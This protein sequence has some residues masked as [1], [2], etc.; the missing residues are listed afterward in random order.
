MWKIRN[1]IDFI[2]DFIIA[3]RS[4]IVLRHD[5]KVVPVTYI[6]CTV[7]VVLRKA[8]IIDVSVVIF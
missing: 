7:G 6:A 1:A 4:G 3:Q 5:N 8:L 2:E